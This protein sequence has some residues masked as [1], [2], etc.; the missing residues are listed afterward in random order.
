MII[1]Q[2]YIA[3]LIMIMKLQKIIQICIIIT[4]KKY[5]TKKD[6][7]K[8]YF[9]NSSFSYTLEKDIHYISSFYNKYGMLD[10]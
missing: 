2:L 7:I 5:Y 3:L 9:N 6:E 10:K 1:I 4:C 8:F